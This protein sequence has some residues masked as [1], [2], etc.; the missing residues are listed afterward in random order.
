MVTDDTC[1]KT[2]LQKRQNFPMSKM[3]RNIKCQNRENDMWEKLTW[4]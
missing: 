4:E 3:T 1:A 2:F